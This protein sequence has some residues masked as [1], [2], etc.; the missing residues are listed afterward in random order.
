MHQCPRS[1]EVAVCMQLTR[2]ERRISRAGC[3]KEYNSH[4]KLT[5]GLLFGFC[6]HMVCVFIE[7]MDTCVGYERSLLRPRSR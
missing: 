6:P 1:K 7:V 5:P 2:T 4:Q 3:N